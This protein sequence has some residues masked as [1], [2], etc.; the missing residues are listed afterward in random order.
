MS[1][2]KLSVE[3]V[4]ELADDLLDEYNEWRGDHPDTN[5]MRKGF[6]VDR[7]LPPNWFDVID[8][9]AKMFFKEIK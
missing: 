3:V 8:P 2:Y 9:N 5:G 6:F 4:Y 7:F 1:Y